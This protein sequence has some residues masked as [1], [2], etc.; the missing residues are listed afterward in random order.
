MDALSWLA[1]AKCYWWA[2]TVWIC[3]KS[4]VHHTIVYRNWCTRRW[5]VVNKNIRNAHF[6]SVAWIIN[7][8]TG[9]RSHGWLEGK[10]LFDSHCMK[11]P[12]TYPIYDPWCWYIYLQNWVIFRFFRAN[13]AVHIPAPWS[14]WV[15]S[16]CLVEILLSSPNS[17]WVGWRDHCCRTTGFVPWKKFSCLAMRV[18][19]L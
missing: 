3:C 11:S 9:N 8:R 6:W 7:S 17:R 19:C 1:L 10:R 12:G 2:V 13:V 16:S 14:T 4:K 5:T 15:S 18:G